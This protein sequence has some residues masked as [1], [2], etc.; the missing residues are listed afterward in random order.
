MGCRRYAVLLFGYF[1]VRGSK[2]GDQSDII[3]DVKRGLFK[4]E[5]ETTGS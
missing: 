3:T 2:A 4:V 1:V 5:I